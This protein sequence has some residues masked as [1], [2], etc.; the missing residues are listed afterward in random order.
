M[1]NNRD[2]EPNQ[3]TFPNIRDTTQTSFA[4]RLTSAVFRKDNNALLAPTLMES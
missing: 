3:A 1:Y 4:N 2:Q